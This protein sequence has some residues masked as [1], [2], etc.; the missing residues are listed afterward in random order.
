MIENKLNNDFGAKTV[1]EDKI[2]YSIQASDPK[3][4]KLFEAFKNIFPDED[5]D[6]ELI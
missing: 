1:L 5:L 4:A 6:S 3:L 2:D